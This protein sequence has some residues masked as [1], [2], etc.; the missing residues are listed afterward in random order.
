[1]KLLKITWREKQ[2]SYDGKPFYSDEETYCNSIE[3]SDIIGAYICY[4]EHDGKSYPTRHI[5]DNADL[6]IEEVK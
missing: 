6:K 1:M 5:R 2:Y 4:M 3:R